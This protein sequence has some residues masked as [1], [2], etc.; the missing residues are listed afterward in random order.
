M[1]RNFEEKLSFISIDVDSLVREKRFVYLLDSST[2][3]KRNPSNKGWVRVPY[4]GPL[5]NK[6]A[7]TAPP[8]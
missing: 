3:R 4:S 1:V 2:T 6:I 5:S 8:L 7:R